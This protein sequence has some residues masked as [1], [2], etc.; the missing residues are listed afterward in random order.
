MIK[1]TKAEEIYE[2]NVNYEWNGVSMALKHSII[3]AI[4]EALLQTAVVGQS[5]RFN[6]FKDCFPTSDYKC[7]SQCDSCKT[8]NF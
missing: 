8:S 1:M 2:R 7:F 5:E 3:K 4:N 6:C